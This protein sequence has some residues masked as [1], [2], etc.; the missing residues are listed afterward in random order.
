MP[1][2]AQQG[3]KEAQKVQTASFMICAFVLLCG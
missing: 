3:H 2:A 1:H